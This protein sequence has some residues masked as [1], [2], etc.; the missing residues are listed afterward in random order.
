MADDEKYLDKETSAEKVVAEGALSASVALSTSVSAEM[1]LQDEALKSFIR[2]MFFG[3]QE[4]A[5]DDIAT[6]REFFIDALNAAIVLRDV[7]PLYY[8]Q[9]QIELASI[10]M[11]D[12]DP[13]SA[14]CFLFDVLPIYEN[15]YPRT[16]HSMLDM[17]H[18]VA[19]AHHLY[20]MLAEAKHWYELTLMNMAHLALDNVDKKIVVENYANL[21]EECRR[22]A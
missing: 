9:V 13:E 22:A 6:A 19:N 15:V 7:H 10:Y 14:I 5:R 3:R 12:G 1:A 11:L 20:G 21:L 18:L 4:L 8:A 17:Y 16:H 2:S